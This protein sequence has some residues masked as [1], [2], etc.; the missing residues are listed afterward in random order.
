[1]KVHGR[2]PCR[3]KRGTKD[4][5]D[6][7]PPHHQAD[8]RYAVR[9]RNQRVGHHPRDGCAKGEADK[10]DG[11]AVAPYQAA[12]LVRLRTHCDPN[13]ELPASAPHR[14]AEHAEESAG[15]GKNRDDG[16]DQCQ[17]GGCAWAGELT[18]VRLFER[19]DVNEAIR[20]GWS[21]NA[22]L[23][24]SAWRHVNIVY[25]REGIGRSWMIIQLIPN[26]S[27]S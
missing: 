17:V 3:E 15:R 1:M 9:K 16:E 7:G 10:G 8:N 22:V 26:R 27:R 14:I 12:D 18:E 25:A 13:P 5:A 23:L 20:L 19:L 4:D 21:S 2:T 11:E 6:C 24:T